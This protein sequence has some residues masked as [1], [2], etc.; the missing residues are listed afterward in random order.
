MIWFNSNV[1]TILGNIWSSAL[2]PYHNWQNWC[3]TTK[4]M[5]KS[6]TYIIFVICFK[7]FH[8]VSCLESIKPDKLVLILH[9]VDC[10]AIQIEQNVP[11]VQ[12]DIHN[13]VFFIVNLLSIQYVQ[14]YLQTL[15]YTLITTNKTQTLLAESKH[16]LQIGYLVRIVLYHKWF[17]WILLS[18][19]PNSQTF[20]HELM[21]WWC[22]KD[23]AQTPKINE[24]CWE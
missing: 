5:I 11:Y 23:S 9:C 2:N 1:I 22:N 20:R 15:S 24:S 17:T 10:I 14:K 19:L 13:I 7:Y 8:C 18:I 3:N 21:K 6:C 12:Y 16:L 4:F